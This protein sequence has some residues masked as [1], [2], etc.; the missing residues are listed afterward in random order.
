[1][2]LIVRGDPRPGVRDLDDH[3]VLVARDF[4]CDVTRLGELQGVGDQ[5]GQD[6]AQAN[7]VAISPARRCVVQSQAKAQSLLLSEHAI[8]PAHAVGELG[9]AEI[10]GSH[11]HFAGF[12]L[13]NVEDVVDHAQERLGGGLDH[14]QA[15]GLGWIQS[16]PAHHMGHAEDT[17]QGRADLVAHGGQKFRFRPVRSLGFHRQDVQRP[18]PLDHPLL[19]GLVD[20]FDLM[21][22]RLELLHQRQVFTAQ[23]DRAHQQGV[24]IAVPGD[25]HAAEHQSKPAEN[26]LAGHEQAQARGDQE[27]ADIDT[28]RHL[29][30]RQ[31]AARARRQGRNHNHDDEPGVGGLHRQ[32]RP[33]QARPKH[34]ADQ[35]T[36][37]VGPGPQ[38]PRFELH[39]RTIL[40][41]AA[42]RAGGDEPHRADRKPDQQPI[43]IPCA[44][45]AIGH[46]HHAAGGG[47][48]HGQGRQRVFLGHEQQAAPQI[49]GRR[50]GG[51]TSSI[52]IHRQYPEPIKPVFTANSVNKFTL[53]ANFIGNISILRSSN[54]VFIRQDTTKRRGWTA[55]RPFQGR[56]S[57]GFQLYCSNRPQFRTLDRQ[58]DD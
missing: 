12:N 29:H 50:R 28:P 19:E 16:P 45:R 56:L 38:P 57:M 7:L 36:G 40:R 31:H 17:V 13:G 15:F 51:H 30:R 10:G 32:A 22:M 3:A 21:I 2:R 54:W 48:L 26:G 1:M 44:P 52:R 18:C 34:A 23:L 47:H 24:I 37:G 9:Q 55:C 53:S 46:Q 43:G 5:I 35:E 49:R 6:L 20:A 8:E 14:R 25:H 41:A 33:S 58:I 42:E 11:L 4:D 39:I 27:E